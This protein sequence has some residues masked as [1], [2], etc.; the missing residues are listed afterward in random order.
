MDDS[1]GFKIQDG[2]EDSVPVFVELEGRAVVGNISLEF[3]LEFDG[4]CSD[5][6]SNLFACS[7]ST[8]SEGVEFSSFG[9]RELR[10]GLGVVVAA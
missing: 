4:G 10:L 7:V 3:P 1:V 8:S 6:G 5:D 2:G 9:S